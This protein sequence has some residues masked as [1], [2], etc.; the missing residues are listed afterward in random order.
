MNFL[1]PPQSSLLNFVRYR[2]S[3]PQ[4]HKLKQ[5]DDKSE[6]ILGR[7]KPSINYPKPGVSEKA[8]SDFN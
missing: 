8:V 7:W 3:R 5:P 2:K 1:K 6:V 4:R